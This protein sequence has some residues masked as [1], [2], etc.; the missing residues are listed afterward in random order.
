MVYKSN[1]NKDRKLKYIFFSVSLW[2][3]EN[4]LDFYFK[5]EIHNLALTRVLSYCHYIR[6]SL[7]NYRA[8]NKVRCRDMRKRHGM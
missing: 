6:F 7:R 4:R 3:V 8:I 2:K 1:I 5:Y